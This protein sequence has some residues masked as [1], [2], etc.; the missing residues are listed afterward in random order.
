M[1]IIFYIILNYAFKFGMCS[2]VDHRYWH[3]IDVEVQ[4]KDISF[5]NKHYSC[6]IQ[7][8]S[9]FTYSEMLNNQINI[10]GSMPDIY[11]TAFKFFKADCMCKKNTEKSHHHFG[12]ASKINR[13]MNK[14]IDNG[15]LKNIVF[16]INMSCI[17]ILPLWWRS[18][19]KKVRC[20]NSD[21]I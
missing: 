18:H 20:L 5:P 3:C 10:F 17:W 21:L 9:S 19:K 11:S 1:E 13:Q 12:N 14:K 8:S 4:E 7:C 2:F 6:L 15:T 16:K